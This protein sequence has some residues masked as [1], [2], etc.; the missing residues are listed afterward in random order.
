MS[1]IATTLSDPSR[2]CLGSRRLEW[3]GADDGA[4]LAFRRYFDL[5]QI[6]FIIPKEAT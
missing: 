6:E 3:P 2:S 5:L 1:F 4:H